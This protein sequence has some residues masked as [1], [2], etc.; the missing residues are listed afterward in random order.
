[1]NCGLLAR[2]IWSLTLIG[3]TS[4]IA[5]SE[6]PHVNDTRLE[7]SLFAEDPDIVTP[8]GMVIDDRDR[9]YVIESH[10]HHP[11]EDYE[12]PDSDRIKRFV[13][14]DQDGRADEIKVFAEGIQ[15]AMNLALSPD[16]DLYVACAREVIRLV[17][18]DGDGQCD[19]KQQILRLITQQRYAHNS[20][21]GITFDR[22]GW[23]YIARG[24]TGSNEYRLEGHDD[25]FVDGYGDGGKRAPGQRRI[26]RRTQT[27]RVDL[28]ACQWPEK[29]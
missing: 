15:Q 29:Q 28:M 6:S 10:T 23:M 2:L 13:D 22:D 5:S 26:Q 11:P 20:L 8:I 14:K 4:E 19:E 16:G 25:S 17:D 24:N 21:L 7:L 3:I 12:G 27:R 18:Q 9:I 1:M